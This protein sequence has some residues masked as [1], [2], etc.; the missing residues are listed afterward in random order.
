MLTISSPHDVDVLHPDIVVNDHET[1][2]E[3]LE[4]SLTLN[5]DLSRAQSEVLDPINANTNTLLQASNPVTLGVCRNLLLF[6]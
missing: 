4:L 1:L 6:Y 2:L 5:K 3:M